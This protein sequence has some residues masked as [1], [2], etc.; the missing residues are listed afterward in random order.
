MSFWEPDGTMKCTVGTGKVELQS[1]VEMKSGFCVK[2]GE[3]LSPPCKI[4][5]K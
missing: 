4:R 3:D 5:T 2:P 1:V